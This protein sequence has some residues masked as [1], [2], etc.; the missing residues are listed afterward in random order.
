MKN[1]ALKNEETVDDVKDP[2]PVRIETRPRGPLVVEGR[3]ELFD[4]NGCRVN[5]PNGKVK[6]CRCGASK[7]AP[8]CDASHN[9]IPFEAE[10]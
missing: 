10:S 9:R 7:S 4:K 1:A 3:F 5:L 6:L 2:A 8:F